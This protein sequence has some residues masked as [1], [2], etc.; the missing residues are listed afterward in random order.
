[1]TRRTYAYKVVGG[2]EILADVYQAGR[3]RSPV[4]VWLHGG[5]LMM[6]HRGNL[7]ESQAQEYLAAGYRVVAIDYRLAPETKLP[8]IIEDL[9]D[10][11]RWVQAIGPELF[12]ADPG[13]IG[14]VGG[15][16]GGYLALMAGC[17]VQPRPRALVSF[18]GYGDIIGAWYSKPDPGYCRQPL[19]SREEALASVG[20][21]GISGT[22]GPNERWRCYL[23]CRQQGLWPREVMGADP[24]AEP[25]RF[26]PFCP[27]RQVSGDYP[28]TLLLHGDQDTDV[29]Y[30]R[31]VDMAAALARAGVQHELVTIPGGGHGFDGA[32]DEA[33]KAARRKVLEFLGKHLAG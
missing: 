3:R 20:Q 15:S 23:Y 19:V 17:C 26:W 16:A 4:I 18:Y 29:P 6:G 9:Q 22:P 31:S 5:A 7:A 2:N 12:G 11:F 14:V 25:E 32:G 8:A 21:P 10:A 30:A 28:P 13:R 24:E 33:A 1:M 27:E